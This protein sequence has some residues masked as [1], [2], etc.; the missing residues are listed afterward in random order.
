[1]FCRILYTTNPPASRRGHEL[2][3]EQ[4]PLIH[5]LHQGVFSITHCMYSVLVIAW[6]W[7]KL[8]VYSLPRTASG[9]CLHKQELVVLY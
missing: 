8:G 5:S 3:M 4:T 6:P 9:K 1:M 7:C 2:L